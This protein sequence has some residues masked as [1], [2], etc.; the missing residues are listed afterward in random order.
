MRLS[1]MHRFLEAPPA[2]LER[3]RCRTDAL[4]HLRIADGAFDLAL[5][6]HLLF[7]HSDAL[8][9]VF[10][11]AAVEEMS[12]VA[13]EVRVFPLLG[14]FG[15]PLPPHPRPLVCAL[16]DR[17]VR[18]GYAV[19]S[20]RVPNEF[21]RGANEV[22]SVSGRRLRGE[23]VGGW[24]EGTSVRGT[25]RGPRRSELRDICVY[26]HG[27]VKAGHAYAMVAVL[28][29]VVTVQPVEAHRG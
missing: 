17:G 21:L 1:A 3:A 7:L 8:S 24:R 23:G 26:P 6:S 13:G 25:R 9:L 5:C 12:R 10:H 16:G 2:G 29:K 27:A 14:A 20:R 4:P 19:E 15:A 11:L 28:D 22:V 18:R